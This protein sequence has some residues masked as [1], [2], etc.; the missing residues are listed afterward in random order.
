VTPC[1]RPAPNSH[2]QEARADR[3][4][5]DL[6]GRP[7]PGRA[8]DKR[9]QR[10]GQSIGRSARKYLSASGRPRDDLAPSRAARFWRSASGFISGEVS[11]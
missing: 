5:P 10:G 3:C 7:R 8:D 11:A 4:P 2:L 6:D 9:H 1:A